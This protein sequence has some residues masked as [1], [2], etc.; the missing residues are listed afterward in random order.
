MKGMVS[1]RSDRV[2]PWHHKKA[3]AMKACSTLFLLVTISI[4]PISRAH[5][6]WQ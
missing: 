4:S 5:N 2:A 3:L 1:Y 6:P